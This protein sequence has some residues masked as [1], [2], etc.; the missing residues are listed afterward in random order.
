MC[1][2]AHYITPAEALD[3]CLY[4]KRLEY[5]EDYMV[6][7]PFNKSVRPQQTAF[8]SKFLKDSAAVTS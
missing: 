3:S 5:E 8:F 4:F 1:H 7:D 6:S 2:S